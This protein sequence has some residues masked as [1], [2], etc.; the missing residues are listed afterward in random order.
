MIFI[1]FRCRVFSTFPRLVQAGIS[2]PKICLGS[3]VSGI[4]SKRVRIFLI[5]FL[6]GSR[7]EF[8]VGYTLIF[9]YPTHPCPKVD[10]T[11]SYVWILLE[12]AP[13]TCSTCFLFRIQNIWSATICMYLTTFMHNNVIAKSA[14]KK[15]IIWRNSNFFSKMLIFASST[16]YCTF[17]I[18]YFGSF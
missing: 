2:T 10:Y 14:S 1:N 11:S 9:G 4:F 6:V 8:R 16:N 17:C 18:S 15:E 5:F 3:W 7:L 12:V 13:E